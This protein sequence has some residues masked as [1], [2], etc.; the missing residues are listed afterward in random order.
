MR[1]LRRALTGV[2]ILSLSL[3][4]I[5]YAGSLVFGA[6]T[7]RMNAEPRSFPQREQVIAVNVVELQP[8]RIAPELKVFGEI[9]SRNTVGIRGSVGGTVVYVSDQMIEGGRVEAGEILLRVDPADA[10]ADL[11]RREAELADALAAERDAERDLSIA[12]DDLIAAQEQA[13][14]RASALQRQRDLQAR[15]IGTAP[16]LEAAELADSSARQ[17]VLARRKAV[18]QAEALIDQ[19]VNRTTLARLNVEEARR[20]LEG[21]EIVAA[22]D[23]VL[24]NVGVGV[25]SRITA[26]EQVATLVDPNALE[27]AL[28][29]ST[30]QYAT[31]LDQDGRLRPLDVAIGLDI[32]GIDLQV[33]GRIVRESPTVGDGLTGRLIFAAIDAAASFRA[34]DFVS[35]TVREPP[36]DGIARLPA[37]ALGPDGTIL[38][39]GEEDRLE[40]A[41]VELVRRQGDDVLVRAGEFAG[42]SAVAARTPLLG[43]GIKV[44]PIG[45]PT[46]EET[47]SAAP[48][49]IPEMVKLDPDRRARLVAYVEG[50]QRMPDEAKTRLLAQLEQD[51]VPLETVNRLESRMGG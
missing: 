33:S 25:G 49:A 2:F 9:R 4:I 37:T 34:G 35:V 31:L 36:I 1:F 24:S 47:A 8:E 14:L 10:Q 41:E 21:T 12:R 20:T 42:R 43:P 17:T 30:A 19:N 15:G 13:D 23:G 32:E 38:V 39:L 45:A 46:G 44:R 29:V 22:F 28:R 11:A 18:A 40:L 5:G 16:E 26:N 48:P 3:A 6:V 50:N 7:D 27:V 51:E